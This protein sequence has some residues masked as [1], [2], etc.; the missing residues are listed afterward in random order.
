MA[1]KEGQEKTI[2]RELYTA[3]NLFFPIDKTNAYKDQSGKARCYDRFVVEEIEY[4]GRSIAYVKIQ[5]VNTKAVMEVG[6]R[7][8]R[9]NTAVS[10]GD[11]VSTVPNR[12]RNDA[13]ASKTGPVS[14]STGSDDKNTALDYRQ[15]FLDKI[16]AYFND[17][18]TCNMVYKTIIDKLGVKSTKD[19]TMDQM[20]AAMAM[21]DQMAASAGVVS[22]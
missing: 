7:Q 6:K 11:T 14:A 22:A 3:P 2:G 12:H 9:A 18:D 21:V 17:K 10:K 19:M 8:T 16:K 20:T 5:D 15:A 1:K 13:V 4:A